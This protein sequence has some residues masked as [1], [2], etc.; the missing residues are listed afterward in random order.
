MDCIKGES[1]YSRVILYGDHRRGDFL[2]F[3]Y[4]RSKLGIRTC[5]EE[6]RYV[7]WDDFI[8]IM[9]HIYPCPAFTIC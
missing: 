6:N 9:F 2:I 3:D 4:H 1:L 7:W 8:F 5:V